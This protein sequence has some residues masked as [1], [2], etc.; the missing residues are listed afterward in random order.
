MRVGAE[1]AA[2]WAITFAV[3]LVTLSTVTASEV[4]VA[5]GCALA[6]A[7]PAPW[8]RRAN[9]GVWKPQWGWLRWVPLMLRQLPGD[10]WSV[11]RRALA[12]R[13]CEQKAQWTRL[14]LPNEG[15]DVAATRRAVATLA[16][17]ATP[18]TVVVDSDPEENSIVLHRLGA[19]SGRLESAVTQ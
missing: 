8:L 9:D 17:G 11:W 12:G 5:A 3:W 1:V 2:W 16:L 6:C 18:G 7:I 19:R 14:Q 13:R 4:V 15:A 10:T